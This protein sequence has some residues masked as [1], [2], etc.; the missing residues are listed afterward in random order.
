MQCEGL[1]RG[2]SSCW[3]DESCQGVHVREGEEV[4]GMGR[5]SVFA[6]KKA[7]SETLTT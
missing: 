6:D 1:Q 3:S 5:G 2:S 7:A 4:G